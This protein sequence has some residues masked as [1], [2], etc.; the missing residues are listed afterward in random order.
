[1]SA[2]HFRR[3]ADDNEQPTER[4]TYRR[5]FEYWADYMA[6]KGRPNTYWAELCCPGCGRVG[7]LGSNHTVSRD[8][9]VQPSNVC[10]FKP[11]TF[12]VYIVLDDWDRPSTPKKDKDTSGDHTP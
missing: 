1:M 8:G 4:G 5:I 6:S 11:C 9:T 10:P 12:H 7:L 2:T 3:I